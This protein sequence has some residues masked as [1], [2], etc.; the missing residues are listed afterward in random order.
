MRWPHHPER[1]VTVSI[2]IGGSSGKCSIEPDQWITAADGQRYAAKH[3]GRNRLSVI[4]LD[5]IHAPRL[6][7]AG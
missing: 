6:A 4:D 1:G 2:G 7:D 5:E 3:A